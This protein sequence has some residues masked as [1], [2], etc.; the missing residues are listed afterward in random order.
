MI[1]TETVRLGDLFTPIGG[2]IPSGIVAT[3]TINDSSTS[4]TNS[5]SYPWT[6]GSSAFS[7]QGQKWE[8]NRRLI[9]TT[10]YDGAGLYPVNYGGARQVSTPRWYTAPSS[11][12][13]N[14]HGA[15]TTE[16]EFLFTGQAFS[17]GFYNLG[18]AGTYNSS[19]KTWAYGGDCQ[20]WIEYGGLMWRIA[21]NPKTTLKT[22]DGPTYRNI[23]FN[24]LYHGRIRVVLSTANF[25][26][27]VTEQSAIVSPAPPRPFYILDGDSYTESTQALDADSSTGWFSSGI[28]D[29]IFERTGMVAARRG[30]GATGL[31]NNGAGTVFDDTPG[32]QTASTLV[33]GDVTIGNSSRFLSASR[34]GWM[35]QAA[36]MQTQENIKHISGIIPRPAFVADDGEDFGQPKGKRPL[37]YVLN[38]TWNDASGGGVTEAQMYARAKECYQ[39]IRNL[40]KRCTFV[41]ISP[42]PFNDGMFNGATGTGVVGAPRAGD[43]SDIHRQGQMRAAAECARVRYVNAFGPDNP[44]WTGMGP[45][46]DAHSGTQGVPTNSQQAQLVSVHDGIHARMEGYRYYANKIAD[47]LAEIR[48]PAVRAFG[49]A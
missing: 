14:E 40:D 39:A 31:V 15:H 37:V 25:D 21:D 24:N 4:Y 27:I 41:H 45:A 33:F 16:F 12:V 38:G 49:V 23:Q 43:K 28:A 20:I 42:E 36:V 11:H 3:D 13:L 44:W 10:A 26:S 7:I 9:L 35:T 6:L 30:Q 2:T 29:F 47:A 46:D 22:S 18:G 17:L 5:A 19:T 32:S 48:I 8:Y 34:I 1:G